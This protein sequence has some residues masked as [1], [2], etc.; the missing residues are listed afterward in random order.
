[1]EVEY[2]S[3][4]ADTFELYGHVTGRERR[5]QFT[6]PENTAWKHSKETPETPWISQASIPHIEGSQEGELSSGFFHLLKTHYKGQLL[7]LLYNSAQW[8]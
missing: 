6:Q 5:D 8:S 4:P 2:L 1:M 7:Q 3:S